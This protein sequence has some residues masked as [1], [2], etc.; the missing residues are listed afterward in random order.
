[1]SSYNDVTIVNFYLKKYHSAAMLNITTYGDIL[2][3]VKAK[4][5]RNICLENALCIRLQHFCKWSPITKE[6]PGF[7][8]VQ[9]HILINAVALNYLRLC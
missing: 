2:Q 1:M 3:H 4:P 6:Y 9:Y 8:E 5:H 7:R